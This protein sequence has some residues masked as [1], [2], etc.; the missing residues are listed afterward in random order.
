[1][2]RHALQHLGDSRKEFVLDIS[3]ALATD[4]TDTVPAGEGIAREAWR[5]ALNQCTRPP[6]TSNHRGN[7]LSMKERVMLRWKVRSSLH[8]CRSLLLVDCT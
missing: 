5:Q 8:C 4:G 7:I 6:R 1:M 2:T 3:N